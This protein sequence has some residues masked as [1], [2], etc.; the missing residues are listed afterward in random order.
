MCSI[1]EVNYHSSSLIF[2]DVHIF[3]NT[4]DVPRS[5]CTSSLI[6]HIVFTGQGY[7]SIKIHELVI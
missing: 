6:L 4:E 7:R 2:E 1:S 3:V 5:Y